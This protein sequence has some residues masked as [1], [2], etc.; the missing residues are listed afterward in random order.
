MKTLTFHKI[1]S[2]LYT[3]ENEELICQ[4]E[5]VGAEIRSLVCKRTNKEFIW[6]IN[7]AIWGSSSPVLFPAIGNIK[8]NKIIHDQKDYMMS[9]HGIV[10]NNKN[11]IFLKNKESK[12]SFTLESSEKT[13]R[14]YP[15][16]FRFEVIYQLMDNRL[17]MTYDI[18][19]KSS[20]EMYFTC[21]GHTAYSLT[22][23]NKT[24][25]TDYLVEFPTK[26]SLEAETLGESGLLSHKKRNF[27][28]VNGCLELNNTLFNDDALIFANIDFD[29]VRLRRKNDD[30]GIVI[31]FSGYPNLALWSKPGADY[32]CVE[33][34]LGLP[35][36]EDESVYIEK[37][38]TFKSLNPDD[39]YSISIIT[40]IES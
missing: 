19:N 24:P 35:D 18:T 13:K 38:P 34:W 17:I 39:S 4:I 40:E 22:L 26:G 29:W 20:V 32:I 6:Q 33:P 7:P 16:D 15:F 21:G 1:T 36:R 25:L 11:L 2:M 28:L 30:R 31:R 9:K 27:N 8:E 3:I 10:R 5:S 23:D 37:K 14:K 12:C